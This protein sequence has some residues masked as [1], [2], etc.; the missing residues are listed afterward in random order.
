M[1]ETLDSQPL[2]ILPLGTPFTG[3]D[4]PHSLGHTPAPSPADIPAFWCLPFSQRAFFR[5]RIVY[6]RGFEWF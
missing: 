3:G 1:V 4:V 5:R 2:F 6:N